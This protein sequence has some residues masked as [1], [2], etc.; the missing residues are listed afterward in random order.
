MRLATIT[1]GIVTNVTLP[2]AGYQP[3]AGEVLFNPALGVS[4]G[5]RYDGINF[6]A[7]P[8]TTPSWANAALDERYFWIDTGP[9]RDRFGVDWLAI[10]ASANDLCKAAA[11]LWLD[12]KHINIKDPRNAQV[13]DALIAANQP[14]A[15]VLFA[16][17]GPMTPAKKAAIL[18][19]Q[20][21]E[22]ERHVKGM[23]QPV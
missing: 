18:S 20:T 13:L 23:V 5:W 3:Q 7:P 2:S 1:S 14:A 16:G 6:S 8:S 22:Y 17:A 19:P 12:R 15:N 11:Q 21:T 10:T 4:P 9:W